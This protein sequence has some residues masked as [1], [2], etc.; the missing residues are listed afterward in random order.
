MAAGAAA[1][2]RTNS[3]SADARSLG[4]S[5][6]QLYAW[7]HDGR[8]DRVAR[9]IFAQ[10][11]LQAD[12]DLLEVAIRAP[13]GILC[14]TSAL[15]RHGLTDDI[16]AT[17]DVALPRVRR[18]P[19]TSAPVTWHRFDEV[20]FD[21]DRTT[22]TVAPGI[23]IGLYGPVRSIVDAFR[24]RHLYGQEQAVEALRRWLRQPG[25]SP[26]RLLSLARH[27]PTAETPLRRAMEILL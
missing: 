11:G 9:G 23:D 2:V 1:S 26:A 18:Q 12:F 16:P 7:E 17:I 8:I 21:L 14:L 3:G 13:E 19:R 22:L 4:V 10:P 27:F 15:A 20:T 6:R 25:N 24:L 5:D